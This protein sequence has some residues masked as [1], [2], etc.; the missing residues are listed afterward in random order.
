LG[1][2][3]YEM[4]AG[5]PPYT[6]PTA[7]AIAAKM[8]AGDPPSIRRTRGSVPHG[9]DAAV[10]K[11]LSPV[12]ADRYATAALFASALDTAERAAHIPAVDPA[13]GAAPSGT[14]VRRQIPTRAAVLALGVVV[15]AGLLFAWRHRES[16][17]ASAAATGPVGVAVLPF[18]THGDTTNAYF[19][20]GITDEI[21]SKLSALGGLRVIASTS[22]NQYRGTQKRTQEIGNDLGV[23]YLLIGHIQWEQGANGVRRVRVSPELVEVRDGV[24]PET[25]WQQSYDTTVAD[26]FDVQ[27]AV[28]TKVADKLGVVLTPPA[29][30]QL[31]AHPTQNLEA[32]DAYLR[33]MALTGIDPATVR[34]ALV[35]AERAV[36]LDS[37]FAG[38]WA[39]VSWLRS[40]LYSEAVPTAADADAARQA[41]ERAIALA[42]NSSDGYLARGYYNYFV[43]QNLAANRA[44]YEMAVRLNPSSSD[45][46][47]DLASA[48]GRA[49]Q[50]HSRTHARPRR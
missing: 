40:V 10:R 8:M 46:L 6:G 27:A 47:G 48:E 7:Q 33:S 21:R 22:S 19:A 4:L 31:A 9:V 23:H 41:A 18:D 37:N 44:A 12:P 45:A 39:R 35:D 28:A 26:V 43:T 42:P 13:A 38:A 3:A 29:Q 25:R 50:W 14:V 2:V 5:E 32:Y 36:A 17:T 30:M 11:A 16:G 20:E 49:G 34:R 1:V 15:G 24:A